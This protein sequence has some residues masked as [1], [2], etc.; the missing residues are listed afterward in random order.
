VAGDAAILLDPVDDRG[1][2]EALG[3]VYESE[4]VRNGLVEAGMRQS[5]KFSW[6]KY[7]GEVVKAYEE[8]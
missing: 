5:S 7:A 6:E 2:V 8:M 3:R 1:F 4:S